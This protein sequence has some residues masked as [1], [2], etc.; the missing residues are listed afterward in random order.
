VPDK[1]G[2]RNAESVRQSHATGA[3]GTGT[4]LPRPDA[5]RDGVPIASGE[6]AEAVP[7]ARRD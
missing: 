6:G 5:G 3:A 4:A 2:Q 7:D 1:R